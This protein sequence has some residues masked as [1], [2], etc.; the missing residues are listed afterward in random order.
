MGENHF[1]ERSGHAA[2]II[3]SR[4][5]PGIVAFAHCEIPACITSLYR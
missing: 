1:Y 3:L 5:T 2:E 4:I